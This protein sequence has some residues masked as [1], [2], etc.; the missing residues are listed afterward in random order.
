MNDY[1]FPSNDAMFLLKEVLSIQEHC[2]KL[3]FDDLND[4]LIT[5]IIEEAAKLG[6]DLLAPLNREGDTKGARLS[7]Q[8]VITTPGFKEAYTTFIQS[9]WPSLTAKVE[10]EGQGLPIALGRVVDEIWLSSN[11]AFS[12]CPMLSQGA[13]EAIVAHGASELKSAFLP[14]MIEGKWTGTMNLTEPQAGSD[15]ALLRTSAMPNEDHYLIKGQKIFIT[16]GEHDMAE[17][18]IHLVLA[19]LPD[20]PNGVKGISLFLVPKYLINDDG[21]L[22][23][24]N[25]V[26]CTSIEHKLG[27]HGSPTCTVNFGDNAG[28]IG[29]L[30]GEPNKG[31]SCMFTMMNHARQGVGTQG[32]GLSERAYQDALDYAKERK[33]GLSHN[34]TLVN[35]INHADVKRMLLTMKTGIAAMRHLTYKAAFDMDIAEKQ[36]SHRARVELFTP[37]VKGWITELAQELTS[38]GIQICGGMGYIEETGIA[39]HYRDARILPIYEGTTGIQGQDFVFRKVV[40]DEGKAVKA[41]LEEMYAD[42]SLL[43]EDDDRIFDSKI[44]LLDTLKQAQNIVER[45]ISQKDEKDFLSAISSDTLMMFGFLIGGWLIANEAQKAISQYSSQNYPSAFLNSK[46][47]CCHF[48]VHHHLPRAH[49][50]TKSIV[51]GASSV[52]QFDVEEL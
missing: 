22:G 45:I 27:I 10:F 40:A 42:I 29:Y 2:Q 41:L 31:L 47:N 4:E 26:F 39:Q 3:G 18:I 12:L 7:S 14:S 25:D 49:A 50:L 44:R 19:R 35:I 46:V 8:E 24:R 43:T 28:A 15:L 23:A 17:N 38:L 52:N 20:A 9:G 5:A 32:L 48:Y 37:I 1:N 13:I 16:W 36:A 21:S 51:D 11:L 33:Q 30:V 34:G 6:T